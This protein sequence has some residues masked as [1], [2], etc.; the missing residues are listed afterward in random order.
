MNRRKMLGGLAATAG[1]LAWTPSKAASAYSSK[2]SLT[3]YPSEYFYTADGVFDEEK[4]RSA[5]FELFEHHNYSLAESLETDER[6][7]VA[8]FNLGDY[9]NVGMAGIFWVNDKEHNYF[10]HEI[11][12]L[13]GQ[14]IPEH[15]HHPAEDMP[16]KHEV[17]QVRNGS[18]HTLSSD[19]FDGECPIELPVSQLEDGI[20]CKCAK[21]LEVGDMDVL[22]K[23][24]EPHFMIAGP[25][26]A[27][28][29]EYAS[30][31][32]G[33]GLRFTNPKASL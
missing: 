20:T 33:E 18:I 17:W 32:S 25:E 14:M 11:Y 26:G 6:F 12:L 3:K 13:P 24:C 30:F 28:V 27:I 16:A 4:A 21:K 10:G 9:S 1:I 2:P 5:Y 7:W 22:N 8:E 31:H 29:T 19:P 23:L 15:S